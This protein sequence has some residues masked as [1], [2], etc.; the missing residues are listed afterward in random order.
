MLFS[1][2][3]MLRRQERA[4]ADKEAGLEDGEEG[5]G[6]SGSDIN[7]LESEHES[8]A[9][10]VRAGVRA[11]ADEEVDPR[12]RIVEEGPVFDPLGGEAGCEWENMNVEQRLCAAGPAPAAP[13]VDHAA[14]P[15]VSAFGGLV[16]PPGY[17][18][19]SI[20]TQKEAQHADNLWKKWVGTDVSAGDGVEPDELDP[21]QRFAFDIVDVKMT[22][23]ADSFREDPLLRP[24]AAAPLANYRPLRMLL[25]GSAGTGKSRTI[26][27]IVK[28][29]RKRVENKARHT[30]EELQL[31]AALGAP[32]GCA[33]FHMK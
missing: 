25:F 18:Y 21:W 3:E 22:S 20:V 15:A 16:N 29:L 30:K 26:R 27:A 24:H 6:G 11:L 28:R 5:S 31:S 12:E 7:P 10:D 9:G 33:S 17:E 2:K 23:R 4:K 1:A 19:K 14:A 13:D 8:D 32:T